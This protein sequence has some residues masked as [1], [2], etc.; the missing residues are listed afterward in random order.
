MI[1]WTIRYKILVFTIDRIADD[2]RFSRRGLSILVQ[3]P[4]PATMSR[5]GSLVQVKSCMEVVGIK[6]GF[7]NSWTFKVAGKYLKIKRLTNKILLHLVD[8]TLLQYHKKCVHFLDIIGYITSAYD[9][10][11]RWTLK[12]FIFL[13]M[14][15]KGV[16]IIYFSAESLLRILEYGFAS[17]ND[18]SILRVNDKVIVCP[19]ISTYLLRDLL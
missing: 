9:L 8:A 4:S 7:F 15:P 17:F 2:I 3:P 6:W 18:S 19:I 11:T 13:T 1:C 10:F 12:L 16:S 14:Y 5:V